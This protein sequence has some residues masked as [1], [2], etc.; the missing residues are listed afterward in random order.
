M[1][2]IINVLITLLCAAVIYYFTLPAINLT[3]MGFYTYISIIAVI[4]AVLETFN[5]KEFVLVSSKKKRFI[6]FDL[7]K[8]LMYTIIGIVVMFITIGIV[9]FTCSPMF[10]AKG[11]QTRITVD[12]K[13][14]FNKDFPEVNFNQLPLLDR[15]SSEVLGDRVM[16]QMSE[17]VSQFNV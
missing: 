13:G 11:Y 15:A 10:N 12:E 2:R 4:F 1:R 5:K 16:G 9:N 14:D 8:F 17:L 7:P 3:N 6:S